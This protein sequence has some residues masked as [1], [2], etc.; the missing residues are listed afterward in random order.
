MDAADHRHNPRM[1]HYA[2]DCMRQTFRNTA[3][4]LGRIVG[5]FR[6]RDAAVPTP[7]PSS[8]PAQTT[9]KAEKATGRPLKATT[10]GHAKGAFGR[11]RGL[12]L[13]ILVF[14]VLTFNAAV[15]T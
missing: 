5:A 3:R 1:D 11:P 10:K 13:V 12:F 6:R 14:S 15:A 9:E 2:G 8:A 7:V 4:M